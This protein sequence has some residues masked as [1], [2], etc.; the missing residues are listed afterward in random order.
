MFKILSGGKC[1]QGAGCNHRIYQAKYRIPKEPYQ[2]TP[3]AGYPFPGHNRTD[4][5]R[6]ALTGSECVTCG[7]SWELRG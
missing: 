2:V 5:I 7:C 1:K 6:Q 3:G 4:S